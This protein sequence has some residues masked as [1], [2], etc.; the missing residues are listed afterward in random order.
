[1][2]LSLGIIAFIAFL[3]ANKSNVCHSTHLSGMIIGLLI[4]NFNVNWKN[5]KMEYYKLRLKNMKQKLPNNNEKEIRMKKRV[6]EILDKLNES[7]WESL[8]DQEEK[9][10]TQASKELFGGRPPN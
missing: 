9:Y 3:S 1:M 2:V 4:I 8:T 6:D 5:L 7:G 10:L